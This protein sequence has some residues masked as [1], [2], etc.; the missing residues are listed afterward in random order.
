MSIIQQVKNI[1]KH[2]GFDIVRYP[3]GELYRRKK[4][5]SKYAVD[6]LLDIGANTGQYA[7]MARRIGYRN[8]IVSLEPMN[9][10]FQLL[11][12]KA[13]T[14]ILWEVMA[15]GAG[16]TSGIK[17][18]HVAGNSYSSSI[19]KMMPEH[20]D[21]EP[22]SGYIGTETVMLTTID[23]QQDWFASASMVYLK[24]DTQGY[25][26]EVIKGAEKSLGKIAFIQMELSLTELYQNEKLFGE[27]IEFMKVKEFEIYTLEPGFYNKTTGRLL[28]A[29]VIFYNRSIIGPSLKL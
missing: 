9:K 24:I 28:Q 2:F 15:L 6:L 21:A 12:Q 27:M 10:A 18:L 23:E 22:I 26:W 17:T 4:I 14:D 29:D 19:L 3:D 20:L 25:E 11:K 16:S 7:L 13:S 5:F 8:K 1:C